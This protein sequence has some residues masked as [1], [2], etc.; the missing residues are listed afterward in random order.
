MTREEILQLQPGP[1]ADRLV[2]ERVMGWRLRKRMPDVEA[3]EWVSRDGRATGYFWYPP[4]SENYSPDEFCPSTDIAAA[5][6]VLEALR[7]SGGR[8]RIWSPCAGDDEWEVEL[9]PGNSD[10]A[11]IV[12]APTLP[13][14]IC[15][16]ALL[17]AIGNEDV[18][19]DR[20]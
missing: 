8:Y 16:A 18:K 10:E 11:I 7:R 2:A 4:D 6:Q 9:F 1:L 3:Y 12:R 20:L 15:R 19:D 17:V 5:W 14:A 13:L